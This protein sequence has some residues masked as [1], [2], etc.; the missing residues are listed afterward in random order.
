MH[1]PWL[2]G[3][4]GLENGDGTFQPGVISPSLNFPVSIAAGDMNGDGIL[5]IVAVAPNFQEVVVTLGVGDGTFGTISQREV[6]P[7]GKQPWA[8]VLGNF[9]NDGKLDIGVVNTYNQVD[10]A[11]TSDQ[12]RYEAEYPPVS[13]GHASAYIIQNTTQ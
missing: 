12:S 8:V 10:L 13:G 4:W 6:F 3:R 11:T 7:A 5:D 1:S 9:F 2:G